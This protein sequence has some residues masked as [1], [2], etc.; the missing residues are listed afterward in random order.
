MKLFKKLF[1]AAAA[2][3]LTLLFC[4]HAF[5]D[6]YYIS[7]GFKY[8]ID[9]SSNATIFGADGE[10]S[11]VVIPDKFD[12]RKVIAVGLYAFRDDAQ[13][14]SVSFQNALYLTEIFP[15]AFKNCD[16]LSNVTF[17]PYIEKIG[18]G[19]FWECTS[20]K[21]VELPGG[22]DTVKVDTFYKCSALEEVT[23]PDSVTKIETYAFAECTSLKKLVIGKNVNEIGAKAFLNDSKLTIYCY[24]DTY[25]L[26]YAQDNNIPYVIIDDY[27]KGD[28]NL[29]GKVD[30]SDA[31]LIQKYCAKMTAFSDL[32]LSLADVNGTGVV[33]VRCATTIQRIISKAV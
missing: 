5:A 4:V 26:Q 20:L 15:Y 30:I 18:N 2:L 32:Q 1:A 7:H 28:V 17:S 14:T 13:I 3:T 12:F 23:I 22:I 29:D 31:T 8:T 10:H 33:D 25:A 6:T 16:N 27:Q 24:K 19:A 21:S 9:N 11:D